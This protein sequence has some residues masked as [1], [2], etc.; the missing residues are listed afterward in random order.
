M[1]NFNSSSKTNNKIK[2]ISTNNDIYSNLYIKNDLLNIKSI[3]YIDYL[4]YKKDLMKKISSDI[5]LVDNFFSEEIN[6]IIIKIL[7]LKKKNKISDKEYN[8]FK[9]VYNLINMLELL[10]FYDQY[11]FL[12]ILMNIFEIK[13]LLKEIEYF[14][15]SFKF[16]DLIDMKIFIDNFDELIGKICKNNFFLKS[17]LLII[18]SND[19][20]T[21][22]DQMKNLA[23]KISFDFFMYYDSENIYDIIFSSIL[24]N[25]KISNITKKNNYLN[26][27]SN[28]KN[29]FMEEYNYCCE[30]YLKI[31]SNCEHELKIKF[32]LKNKKNIIKLCENI[33]Y[34][35]SI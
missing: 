2:T 11:E 18:S 8:I 29:I 17:I 19:K 15:N 20:N 16:S 9:P 27:V 7:I 13:Y 12:K 3:Y 33:K 6:D 24:T 4:T 30:S 14:S 22:T 32:K 28:N 23:Q 26:L 31:Y 25:C 1:N 34:I 5:E 21:I 10:D 35:L